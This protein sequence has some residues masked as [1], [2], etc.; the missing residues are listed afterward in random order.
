MGAFFD[1]WQRTAHMYL[2]FDFEMGDGNWSAGALSDWLMLKNVVKRFKDLTWINNYFLTPPTVFSHQLYGL[3]L[4]RIFYD[5]L[6]RSQFYYSGTFLLWCAWRKAANWMWK[7]KFTF[8]CFKW[9]YSLQFKSQVVQ[10]KVNWILCLYMQIKKMQ[11]F[12]MSKNDTPFEHVSFKVLYVFSSPDSL[13]TGSQNFYCYCHVTCL[14]L[15]IQSNV[16]YGL[17]W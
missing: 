7:D 2:C 16:L 1:T 13:Y 10:S 8:D 4:S 11:L 12:R 15:K 17:Q 14:S 5:T 6:S 3:S 9:R